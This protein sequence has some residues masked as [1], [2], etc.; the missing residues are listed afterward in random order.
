MRNVVLREEGGIDTGTGP[1]YP[2]AVADLYR[3]ESQTEAQMESFGVEPHLW[4]A[5]IIQQEKVCD[6]WRWNP[7]NFICF[8]VSF[9][10]D[11]MTDAIQKRAAY[12]GCIAALGGNS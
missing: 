3:R 2:R 4:R 6:P 11:R 12:F 10:C 8:F 1:V 7:S 5:R 9:S